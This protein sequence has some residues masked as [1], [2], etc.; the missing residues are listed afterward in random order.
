MNKK[1]I[2]I[3][4]VILIGAYFYAGVKMPKE[5]PETKVGPEESGIPQISEDIQETVMTELDEEQK[6]L[7]FDMTGY[8][9]DGRKKWDIQG[10]SADIVSD[11][12]IL[13]NIKANAYSENRTVMLQ[14]NSGKYNKKD[15]S[16]RLE[17][18]VIVT[19]SDGI[20]LRAE[21]LEWDSETG[22]I[23]TDSFVEVTKDDL[24]A[25]G[26][27]ALASTKDKEIQL[28]EDVKVKQGE[29]TINCR[30]PLIID[31]GKNEASFYNRVKVTE[32]RGELKADRLDIF[33]NP[34]SREMKSIVAEGNVE[35]KQDA[36]VARGQR[37]IYTIA[38]GKA[39]L[40]GNP[41]ILIYS[42]KDIEDAF[43]GD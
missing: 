6:I 12:A 4:I 41:E 35:L 37:I 27:G 17:D 32:P 22:N 36:N 16:V 33:F 14:A 34:E 18:N 8:T 40:T 24:Y 5:E 3:A 38:T 25:S 43:I 28:E 9:D 21:W 7:S 19:T 31:Y 20:N 11:I 2:F 29:I 30:G 13:N 15:N 1:L 26:R 39:I 42:K 23:K 10:E